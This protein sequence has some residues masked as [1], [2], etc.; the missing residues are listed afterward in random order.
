MT[1]L[2]RIGMVLCLLLLVFAA[3]GMVPGLSVLTP[4]AEA[5]WLTH[6]M[7]TTSW[8]FLALALDGGSDMDGWW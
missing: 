2:K 5:S 8:W 7:A 4:P 6:F 3:L 1:E